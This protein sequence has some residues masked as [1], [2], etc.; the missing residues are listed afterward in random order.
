LQINIPAGIDDGNRIQLSGKGEVGPGGGP[1]GDL[2][3][4]VHIASHETLV[5]DGDDLHLPLAIS[6]VD[7]ALGTTVG[8]DSLDGLLQVTIAQ[9][10]Q[11]GTTIPIR[12]KGVTRLRGSGRGDLFVH[13]EVVIPTKL[14][15]QEAELLRSFAKLRGDKERVSVSNTQGGETG[16]FSRLKEA[17]GR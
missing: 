11:S 13:V 7:A 4:E 8:V 15:E 16:F 10:T 9:G 2:Y 3:V 17:L 12:G 14:S 1:N 5:R 6:M